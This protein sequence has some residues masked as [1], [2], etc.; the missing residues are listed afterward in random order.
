MSVKHS[1][2]KIL[3]VDDMALNIKILGESLR[4]NYEIFVATSGKKALAIATSENP[5]DLILLDIL[6]HEMDGYEVCRILKEDERTKDIPVIFISARGEMED[7]TK[8]LELGAVDYI[9]KPFSMPIVNARIKTHLSLKMKNDELFIAKKQADEA[10]DA[11]SVFL[12]NMSH[13]LRAPLHA[14]IGFSDILEKNISNPKRKDFLHRIRMNGELLLT[15]INEILDLSMIEAGKMEFKYNVV[16]LTNLF[17]ETMQLFEQKTEEKGV[18]FLIN[19]SPTVPEALLLD[20]KRMRQ[21][22]INLLGNAVKFTGNGSI[23]LTADC[24]Y[25]NDK[26]KNKINLNFSVADTGIGIPD[27]Q[28]GNIFKAFEQVKGQD[29]VIHDG[30]GLGLAITKHIVEAMGGRITLESTVGCGSNFIVN[31][32]EVEVATVSNA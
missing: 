11:K 24:E 25:L 21:V 10:N 31:I 6:M 7:E 3:I 17:N 28:H 14:I 26:L 29:T 2:H 23:T 15:L 20:S 13:E 16:S 9:I 4:K 22:L 27:V 32:K 19:I 5:P 30:T 1:K 8:G 12:A 18:E